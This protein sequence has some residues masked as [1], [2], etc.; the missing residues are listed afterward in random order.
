MVQVI[1]SGIKNIPKQGFH[2]GIPRE[3]MPDKVEKCTGLTRR[4]RQ[5]I[6]FAEVVKHIDFKT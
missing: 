1:G 5:G 3:T 6:C 2:N 4:N